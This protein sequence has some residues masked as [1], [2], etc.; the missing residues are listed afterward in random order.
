MLLGVAASECSTGSGVRNW[1]LTPIVSVAALNKMNGNS[2]L[3][4]FPVICWNRSCSEQLHGR[5]TMAL[6][7]ILHPVHAL[8]C[9]R[10]KPI[11]TVQVAE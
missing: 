6:T 8:M 4:P 10:C 5:P 2:Q 9:K 3:Q 1:I 7:V 11:I